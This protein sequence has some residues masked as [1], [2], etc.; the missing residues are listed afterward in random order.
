MSVLLGID[1][2]TSSVKSMLLDSESRRIAVEA[3]SYD[4][5][6]PETGYAE[7]QPE[8]WWASLI[9]TLQQLNV[10][11][12]EMFEKISAIS[13]SGQMHGAVL[14]NEAGIPLR[15]AILWLDQRATEQLK[16]I[17]RRLDVQTMG[18]VFGN[19]VVAGFAFPS[20]LW[21]KKHEPETLEHAAALLMPKDYIRLKL[22]G[23]IG[24]EVTDASAT[25]LFYIA[26]RTWAW[27]II[28][29]FGLPERIFRETHESTELAGFI[30]SECEK[31]C[32]LRAGIPVFYGC[33]DQMA[34][35]IGNG[36]CHEGAVISNIG[37]GG[38]ISAYIKNAVYDRKLR[39]HT[40]CHAVD[41]A[42]TIYGATLCS[43][44]SLRWFKDKILHV[45]SF[46]EMSG[47]AAKV[48]AGSGGVIFLPYLTGER[49][50]HMDP[51]AKG[52]FF[53]LSLDQDRASMVRAV[54][55][56][57][58]F[59]LKDSLTIF[60]DLGIECDQIIASGGGSQSDIWL[61]IQADIY[62]REVKVC[63]VSEQACLGACILAGVGSGVLQDVQEGIDRFVSFR[64]RHY[65]PVKEHV[66]IY[67]QQY[68]IFQALYPAIKQ[69][70]HPIKHND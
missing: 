22:T 42:Y 21:L 69:A 1:L 45:K 50:P 12:S 17:E 26:D 29:E 53:G 13:L 37:T 57:V 67:E 31:E 3:A 49:T 52:A 70:M 64:E 8:L 40:F 19:R 9:K 15:P 35:S 34:Q 18:K 41:K 6:I 23:K 46:D 30:T 48:K 58:T 60:Q 5:D 4:V 33:G 10:K 20:L 66:E 63:T 56:G 43:G 39:T 27:K 11:N 62:N 51:D 32:G 68:E 16:E 44:L 54:M 24:C 55:E 61:Q 14:V 47:L 38:Q 65:F 7:Q 2:G 28:R 59:S 25:D 36:V